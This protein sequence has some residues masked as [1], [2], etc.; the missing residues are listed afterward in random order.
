MRWA[1]LF[2]FLLCAIYTHWRGKARHGS[3]F[4]QLGDHSTFMAPLN[5]F[6]Y[7]FS[8]VP[9]TPY[10]EPTH[11]P[12][13]ALLKS[14]WR[15]FRAEALALQEA[16]RISASDKYND[17]G[18]NSF[19]RTGWKRFYL[20][21]YDRPHPS[22]AQLC[23]RTIEILQR[24]PSVKA[25]M[26]AMLPANGSLNP[27]RDPFAGSLRY[28]LGLITPNDD[29][30]AIVVDGMPYSW[31]DGQDVVFDETYLHHAHNTTQ[32]DRIILFCDI[33]RPMKY[34][35]AQSLMSTVGGVLM[36]AAASPNETG[37][38]TGGLNRAF[39]Y[40]YSVRLAG[41][42]LKAWN[43]TVYYVVKWALFGGIA[44]AIFW[45]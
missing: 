8:K 43:R 32:H 27:H 31:R 3:F 33:E 39:R 26:F 36:R 18:F 34:R 25:A 19:F 4:R 21:W 35:W 42:R 40:V 1:V 29:R 15:T 17:I 38:R 20:K 30:C 5:G 11:F 12:E 45:H 41:K 24:I 23:P 6:A 22:A 14:E 10:I 7:F 28:H 44:L 16:S 2:L 13:L 37:D 9:N